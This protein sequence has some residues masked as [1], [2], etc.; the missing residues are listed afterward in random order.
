MENLNIN[1]V[2]KIDLNSLNQSTRPKKKSKKQ[3]ERE[4]KER[5]LLS[6]K[7]SKKQLAKERNERSGKEQNSN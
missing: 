2:G 3:L 5:A 7:K 6:G 4:R 1:I